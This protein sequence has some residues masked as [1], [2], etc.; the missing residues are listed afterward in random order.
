ML[1]SSVEYRKW[2]MHNKPSTIPKN[3]N[4]AYHKMWKGWGDYLG[5]D[6]PFPCVRKKF[7]SYRDARAWAQ[8]LRLRNKAQWFEYC[9]T[10]NV[11]VDVPRRPDFYYQKSRNW[12]TWKDFLGY[13]AE[14]RVNAVK[15]NDHIIYIIQYP[16]LPTNV[17][18]IGITAEGKSGLIAR[19]RELGFRILDGYYHDKNSDWFGKI[20]PVV[21]KYHVGTNNYIVQNIYDVISALS[22]AYDK[23]T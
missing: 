3:P 15:D 23:V 19:Q 5:T 20:E 12:L 14:D 22:M 2:W 6:N 9:K 10:G 16:E 17:Y 7:R 18:T 4:R 8:T 13:T 1:K 11:P 21:R